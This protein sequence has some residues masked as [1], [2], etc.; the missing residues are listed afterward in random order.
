MV[1]VSPG[2][3]PPDGQTGLI[4]FNAVAI[5][6]GLCAVSLTTQVLH[7]TPQPNVLVV[8]IDR[9]HIFS[10]SLFSES[11][12]R[13]RRLADDEADFVINEFLKVRQ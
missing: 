11:E 4:F 9:S 2:S 6:P 13:V 5:N 10:R 7:F 12:E 1:D 8:G 3:T